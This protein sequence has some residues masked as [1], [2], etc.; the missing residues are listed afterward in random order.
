MQVIIHIGDA[1][2]GS[3]SIQASLYDSRELLLQ[4][5]ILYHPAK[6]NAHYS[7]ITL[8]NGFTRGNNEKQTSI[9]RK[10]IQETQALI[11]QHSPKYLLLSAENLYNVKPE[12]LYPLISEIVGFAPQIHIIGFLRHPVGLFLSTIQQ[13]LK[14][15]HVFTAPDTF[16]RDMTGTFLRWKPLPQTQ[17]MHVRLF[18]RAALKDGSVVFEF[19]ELIREITGNVGIDIPDVTENSSFSVEQII[20]LQKVRH[21]FLSME[22]GTFSPKSNWLIEFFTSINAANG[23]VVGTKPQLLPEVQAC[24]AVGNRANIE[25]V[26]QIFPNL[27]MAESFTVPQVDWQAA[28]KTWTGNV[29]KIL[30]P[31]NPAVYEALKQLTPHYGKALAVGDPNAVFALLD[32]LGGRAKLLPSYRHYLKRHGLESEVAELTKPSSSPQTIFLGARS[33]RKILILGTSN[34]IMREGWTKGFMSV[35]PDNVEVINQ[36]IG[37]SPGAQFAAWCHQDLTIYDHIIFDAVVNDEN[38]MQQGNL[39]EFCYYTRLL[40]EIMST[41]ASQTRLTVLGFCNE[42]FSTNR[43]DMYRYYMTLSQEIGADFHSVIDFAQKLPGPIFRDG[44]HIAL[45]HAQAFGRQLASK[46]DEFSGNG[47]RPRSFA[48]RFRTRHLSTLSQMKPVTRENIFLK[49]D[50]VRLMPGTSVPIEGLGNLI[51]FQID[52]CDTNG[53][54]VLTA[55]DGAKHVQ[56][57]RYDPDTEKLLAFFIPVPN[58]FV[59]PKMLHVAEKA[60]TS[61]ASPHETEVLAAHCRIAMSHLT[62]WDGF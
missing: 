21:D 57:L 40:R 51:G 52:A 60:D 61:T 12:V 32:Q 15:N 1:K 8:L 46:L 44:A 42:R 24:I 23:R 33:F 22:K 6:E 9:A 16:K 54:L 48:N 62:F 13:Q 20:L 29:A 43:S 36:S 37:G 56:S 26:D 18:D 55:D 11:Q 59:V 19:A 30:T 49:Q 28:K 25:S 7:Y 4:H 35:C 41:I 17:S 50:F 58:G 47:G 53:F 3:T 38:M 31:S 2:C 10:N 27:K 5:G 45:N 39:G 34:S 14:A